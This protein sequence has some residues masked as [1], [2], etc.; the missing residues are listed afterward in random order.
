MNEIIIKIME[1]EERRND[2]EK[3]QKDLREQMVI[4]DEDKL[5]EKEM[6]Y[7]KNKEEL[8]EINKYIEILNES[9]EGL[10]Y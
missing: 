7:Y 5:L 3:V 4:A 10:K 1:L 2:I 6:I 8:K 9:L